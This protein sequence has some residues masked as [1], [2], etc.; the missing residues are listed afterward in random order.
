KLLEDLDRA[1]LGNL[2]DALDK[3]L[4]LHTVEQAHTREM[5]RRKGRDAL[6]GKFSARHADRIS[7]RE[8]ARVKYADDVPRI[9]LVHNMAVGRHHLLRLGEAHLLIA[10]YMVDFHSRVK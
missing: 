8:N 4:S 6:I 9:C 1:L 2:V 7:D 3:L 10:L 5:L